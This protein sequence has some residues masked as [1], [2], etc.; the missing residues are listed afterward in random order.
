MFDKFIN[1]LRKLGNLN[2]Q[3]IEFLQEHAI[4]KIYNKNENILSSGS[5]SKCI[6][7]VLDG[8]IRLHYYVEGKDKT[9]FFYNEGNFIWTSNTNNQLY[10]GNKN[11]ETIEDTILVQIDIKNA[12]YLIES[13]SNFDA[14]RR[15]SKDQE[16]ASYQALIASFITLSPEERYL[17]LF[18]SNK[19][20]F[21]KVPQQHIASYL[22]VSAETLCRIKKRIYDKNRTELYSQSKSLAY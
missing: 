13:S 10:L 18:E 6:Y 14:I 4:I 1:E 9:A 5:C 20:L 19:T 8:C 15:I 12:Q 3:E 22:G 11:F 21:Q 7:F 17:R 16:L 2:Q